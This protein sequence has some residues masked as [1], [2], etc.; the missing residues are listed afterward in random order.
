M[1]SFIFRSAL[2]PSTVGGA[3]D[4]AENKTDIVS[5]FMNPL[6]QGQAGGRERAVDLDGQSHRYVGSDNTMGGRGGGKESSQRSDHV[7]GSRENN[8]CLKRV[9][10]RGREEGPRPSPL[11]LD[12]L[13]VQIMSHQKGS[14]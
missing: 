5:D 14:P 11:Q 3:G 8:L 10:V 6:G 9:V 7:C 2:S 1:L 4:T 12:R 13:N